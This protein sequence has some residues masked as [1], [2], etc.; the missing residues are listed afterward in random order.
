MCGKEQKYHKCNFC[1]FTHSP[2]FGDN[3]RY[4]SICLPKYAVDAIEFTK[5]EF[6]CENNYNR[7]M[8]DGDKV[9]EAAKELGISIHDM[10]TLIN[11]AST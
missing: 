5:F 9:I 3:S 7:F 4:F 6:V 1:V 2:R 8:L 11:A 10:L